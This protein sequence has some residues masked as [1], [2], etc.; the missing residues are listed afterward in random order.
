[1]D[2]VVLHSQ[3]TT[4]PSITRKFSF[5]PAVLLVLLSDGLDVAL[6]TRSSSPR[7]GL[8]RLFAFASWLS[9]RRGGGGVFLLGLLMSQVSIVVAASA[10]GHFFFGSVLIGLGIVHQV[11]QVLEGETMDNWESGCRGTPT[12]MTPVMRARPQSSPSP[13]GVHSWPTHNCLARVVTCRDTPKGPH[14]P[15]SHWDP[16]TR[17]AKLWCLS[18]MESVRLLPTKVPI[19]NA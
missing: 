14:T 18:S 12:L 11:G 10:N 4:T 16:W 3:N 6:L 19:P 8:F 15:E 13:S 7:L 2:S 1:M 5:S 9:R 17:F